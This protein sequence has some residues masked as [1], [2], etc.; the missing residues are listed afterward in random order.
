[1]KHGPLPHLHHRDRRHEQRVVLQVAKRC[2]GDHIHCIAPNGARNIAHHL[3]SNRSI[4]VLPLRDVT[5]IAA[6]PDQFLTAR[7]VQVQINN[8]LILRR[9]HKAANHKCGTRCLPHFGGGC[10]ARIKLLRSHIRCH[11]ESL[12]TCQAAGEILSQL[13]HPGPFNVDKIAHLKRQY[14]H[15]GQHAVFDPAQT[16]CCA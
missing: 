10:N 16:A 11:A 2:K 9:S 3:K 13:R 7:V 1:M 15:R 14:G 12:R 6:R 8:H 4:A 5:F